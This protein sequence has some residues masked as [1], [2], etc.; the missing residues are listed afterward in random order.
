MAEYEVKEDRKAIPQGIYKAK[1]VLVANAENY[2]TSKW[3][4]K[5]VFYRITEGNLKD[6]EIRMGYPENVSPSSNFGKLFETLLGRAI[7]VGEKLTDEMLLDIPCSIVVKIE[8][9]PTKNGG[10]FEKNVIESVMKN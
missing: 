6:C 7:K 9:V 8:K 3:K 1:I 5:D 2:E 10:T 4:Y